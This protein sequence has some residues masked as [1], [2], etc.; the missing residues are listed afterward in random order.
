MN[1]HAT[2]ARDRAKCASQA[3]S[4]QELICDVYEAIAALRDSLDEGEAR[5]DQSLAMTHVMQALRIQF[6][7]VNKP[8]NPKQQ[9][10]EHW[11]DAFE[12]P[13]AQWGGKSDD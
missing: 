9:Q 11:L 7:R 5:R 1:F 2:R 13:G 6:D 10:G 3:Q 12:T 4:T 8:A